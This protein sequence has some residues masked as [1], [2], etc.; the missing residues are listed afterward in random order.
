MSTSNVLSGLIQDPRRPRSV[1][2]GLLGLVTPLLQALAFA[3]DER[4]FLTGQE[5]ATRQEQLQK[6]EEERQFQRQRQIREDERAE[7]QLQLL[8]RRESRAAE[9]DKRSQQLHE[10]NLALLDIAFQ[11]E[12]LLLDELPDDIRAKEIE[13]QLALLERARNLGRVVETGDLEALRQRKAEGKLQNVVIVPTGPEEVVVAGKRRVVEGG[14]AVRIGSQERMRDLGF[15]SPQLVQFGGRKITISPEMPADLGLRLMS[16]ARAEH[17]DN[18]RA[19]AERAQ[20]AAARA[21]GATGEPVPKP[22][23]FQ[24]ALTQ[25][26]QEIN[27]AITAEALAPPSKKRFKD[28]RDIQRAIDERANQLIERD[29]ILRGA[30]SNEQTMLS[31]LLQGIRDARSQGRSREEVEAALIQAI[32]QLNA[33][34]IVITREQAQAIQNE[35]DFV[36]GPASP[37]ATEPEPTEQEQRRRASGISPGFGLV[38]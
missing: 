33:Q 30:G 14:L 18:L 2:E 28:E 13:R 8:E 38:K 15:D 32:T 25:A 37:A 34:G 23:T 6:A 36:F 11:K 4:A 10:R 31:A 12:A 17:L 7:R 19:E 24:Q 20:I 16:E 29:R 27:A 9:A 1:G 21:A 26:R 22:L 3:S 5:I 35:V